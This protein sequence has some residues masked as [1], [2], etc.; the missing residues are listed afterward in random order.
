MYGV[1]T[2]VNILKDNSQQSLHNFRHFM[3]KSNS[4]DGLL[5][6]A[7]QHLIAAKP[8]LHNQMLLALLVQHMLP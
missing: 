2:A 1:E 6:K 8:C 5:V 7:A 4:P 3:H